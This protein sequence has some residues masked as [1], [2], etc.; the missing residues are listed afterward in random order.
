MAAVLSRALA[1][2]GFAVLRVD[3]LGCGDSSGDFGDA[4]W[5]HWLTDV[6]DAADWLRARCDA[7][8]WLWGLRAG[9]LVATAAVT[10]IERPCHLLFWHPATSGKMAL[11][12]F[13]RLKAAAQLAA[14]GGK[15]IL[16]ELRSDLAAGKTVQVAGYQLHARLAIG[17]EAATLAPPMESTRGD[18]PAARRRLVWLDVSTQAKA[19]PSPAAADALSQWIAAGFDVASAV[20]QGPMFW[21]TTEIEDAPALVA[22]SVQAL[23]RHPSAAR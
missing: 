21:Q 5:D 22:A 9:C 8:L 7:P 3:L 14:G 16:N 2:A 11:Q 23:A 1:S 4:T 6:A 12:R 18:P 19:E 13:L 17:L 15:A 10:R 20:V